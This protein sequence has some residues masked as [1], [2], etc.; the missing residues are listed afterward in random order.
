MKNYILTFEI[1][2]GKVNKL[3]TGSYL[4]TIND[5]KVLSEF[6]MTNLIKKIDELCNDTSLSQ[7][8]PI[9]YEDNFSLDVLMQGFKEYTN[10]KVIPLSMSQNINTY[11]D[12]FYLIKEKLHCDKNTVTFV[13][14][15]MEKY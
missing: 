11:I 2:E 7:T 4:V 6:E 12:K 13:N 15:A 10:A 9:C 14:N 8:F 1:N 5:E 3:Y